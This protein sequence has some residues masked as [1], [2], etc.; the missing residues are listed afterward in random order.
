MVLYYTMRLEIISL[1]FFIACFV[2]YVYISMPEYSKIVVFDMDETLGH[3][4]QLGVIYDALEK[5]GVQIT[6][7]S[8]NKLLDTYIEYLRPQ[9]FEILR[10]VIDKKKQGKCKN[11]YIYTNNQGPKSWGVQIKKYFENKMGEPFFD[12]IIGAYKISGILN[13]NR[14]STNRKTYSDLKTIT[15]VSSNTKICFLDDQFHEK[16]I[17]PNIYY[18]YLPDYVYTFDESTILERIPKAHNFNDKHQLDEFKKTLHKYLTTYRMK[19]NTNM[20][21]AIQISDETIDYLQKFFKKSTT[22][23]TKKHLGKKKHEKN[24]TKK[25]R[26]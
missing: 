7:H 18:I 21:K 14:R 8:F 26:R 19:E 20:K 1:L 2:F 24:K 15:N 3:F 9:I 17:H 13:D 25:R 11:I 6:Q 12:D 4:S 16:M 10:Y 22:Q 5:C 23:K